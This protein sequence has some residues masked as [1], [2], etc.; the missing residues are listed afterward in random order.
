LSNAGIGIQIGGSEGD[1]QSWRSFFIG[2]CTGLLA[3]ALILIGNGRTTGKPI[4]LSTPREAPGVRVSVRGAVVAP[5]IY[6]L[7][8]GSIVQDAL[9]AAGGILPRGDISRLNLVA[10]LSDGQELRI[11][12][13]TPSPG[14]GT[15]AAAGPEAG[16][17]INLNFATAEELQTL[18]GI[19]PVLA[20]RIV[21]YRETVGPF[22][23]VDDLLS[24]KGIGPSLL[25][26]IRDLVEV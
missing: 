9:Q 22:Q 4:L 1:M 20:Q 21:E 5:G 14:P 24:V 17:I 19:G 2:V 13:E 23:S 12:L 10:P 3:T 18:P 8:P 11:P 7:P 16:G 6:R 26:K 15:P 25:E